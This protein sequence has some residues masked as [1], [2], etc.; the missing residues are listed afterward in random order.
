M[1]EH[2]FPECL[3]SWIVDEGAF[4]AAY[5]GLSAKHRAWLKMN[6]ARH[7]ALYGLPETTESIV[8]TRFRQGGGMWTVSCPADWCVLAI[9]AEY[10][11]APRLLAAVLPALFSGIR[12]LLVARVTSQPMPWPDGLLAA[13]ELAGVETVVSC[14]GQELCSVLSDCALYGHGRVMMLGSCAYDPVL[15]RAANTLH[16]PVWQEPGYD[17]LAVDDSVDKAL[18]RWAHPDMAMLPIVSVKNERIL[19][20]CTQERENNV[21][22]C[23]HLGRGQ[24][25]FFV[26]PQLEAG[27]FLVKSIGFDADP[28]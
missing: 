25:G 9:G 16:L 12:T 18:L 26:W 17:A 1:T 23:I 3:D 6:I 7:Q 20:T 28:Q 11:A 2:F 21:S 8:R 5:T 13:C 14:T 27:F 10:A 22:A 15:I 24:E 19:A 4:A